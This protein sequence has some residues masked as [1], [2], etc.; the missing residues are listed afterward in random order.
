MPGGQLV[1]PLGGGGIPSSPLGTIIAGLLG[2]GGDTPLPWDPGS[3]LGGGIKSHLN[4][5]YGPEERDPT[6]GLLGPKNDPFNA[7]W[8]LFAHAHDVPGFD[9]TGGY[10]R[11]KA[12]PDLRNFGTA[13]DAGPAIM[14]WIA[15]SQHKYDPTRRDPRRG[16]HVD[17]WKEDASAT[18]PANKIESPSGPRAGMF[19]GIGVGA[20][21][22]SLL[23]GTLPAVVIGAVAGGIIG[24]KAGS[25]FP[26]GPFGPPSLLPGP[27]DSSGAGGPRSNPSSSASVLNYLPDPESGGPGNP[28]SRRGSW[29][30]G[31][32]PSP[33]DSGPSNPRSS[34]YRPDPET[35]GPG[36]PHS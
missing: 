22:G 31:Y 18:P 8:S 34:L 36:N 28:R 6:G 13:T 3:G 24:Y 14:K 1:G 4:P 29:N 10:G 23:G 5:H 27:D 35:V 20:I 25:A 11:K 21:A 2:G 32:M 15:D 26:H 9:P 7:V 12:R 16:L 17:W 30:V 19:A 33:D